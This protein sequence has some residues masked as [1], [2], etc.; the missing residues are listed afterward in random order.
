MPP[1]S[2]FGID[3]TRLGNI[4]NGSQ[5]SFQYLLV[6]LLVGTASVRHNGLEIRQIYDYSQLPF[7]A[8]TK[9]PA[10]AIKDYIATYAVGG[11][12][13]RFVHVTTADNR[14]FFSELLAEFLNF[15]IQSGRGCH[16]AAFVYIYRALERMSFS[17]PLL[18]ASTNRDYYNT[19]KD[20]KAMFDPASKSGELGLLKKIIHSGKLIDALMLAVKYDITFS[21]AYGHQ[22]KYYSLVTSKYKDFDSKDQNLLKV[23]IS[24]SKVIDLLVMI[25]NRFF[26]A[27]TGDG[28]PNIRIEEVHDADEFFGILNPVFASFL[29]I[30]LLHSIAATYRV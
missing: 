16:M 8:Q 27:R 12:V 13:K 24:F 26:H 20:L 22:Q 1:V 14:K 17:L 7:G 18:Y 10:L 6:R 28:Q 11:T 21:S 25:R 2:H 5:N 4:P 15:F 30:I 19:F 9:S 3:L 23:E 29:S